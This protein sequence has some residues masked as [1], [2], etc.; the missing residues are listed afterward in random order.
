MSSIGSTLNSINQSLLSEIRSDLSSSQKTASASTTPVST[1]P[2]ID[3][4]DFSQIAELFKELKQL[5]TSNPAEFKKVTSDAASQ[6]KAA[7]QQTTDPNQASFLSELADKF[8]KASDT[9]DVA[10]LQPSSSSANGSYGPHGH[11]HHH[12]GV[13]AAESDSTTTQDQTASLLGSESSSSTPNI[14][15][16]LLG[17][18]N[19]LGL[20]SLFGAL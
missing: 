3:R 12:G 19:V 6:L 9:G 13:Q 18:N 16:T 17:N 15:S 14:L 5:Q 8:Q 1:T 11:H 2:S 20:A 7:V 10:A 4:V